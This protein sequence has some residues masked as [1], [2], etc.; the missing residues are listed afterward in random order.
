MQHE[1]QKFDSYIAS[2]GVAF[3]EFWTLFYY[4]FYNLVS[5]LRRLATVFTGTE[6]VESDFSTLQF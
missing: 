1:L 5:L 3:P 2:G 4:K 6:S